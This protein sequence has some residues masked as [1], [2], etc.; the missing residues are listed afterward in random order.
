MERIKAR[1]VED[2]VAEAGLE[3]LDELEDELA[4]DG[5]LQKYR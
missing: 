2:D 3:E 1:T 4:D 5:M